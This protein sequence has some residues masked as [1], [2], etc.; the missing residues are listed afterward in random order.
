MD[1]IFEHLRLSFCFV[2]RCSNDP[3]V[4]YCPP[5]ADGSLP[6]M[7]QGDPWASL[8]GSSHSRPKRAS[9]RHCAR[10]VGSRPVIFRLQSPSSTKRRALD[11]SPPSSSRLRGKKRIINCT[12]AVTARVFVWDGTPPSSSFLSTV[13]AA[14]YPPTNDDFYGCMVG[15]A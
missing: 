12:V 14:Y 1:S 4:Q 7:C 8:L 9:T 5:C 10:R 11:G 6:C 15:N 3:I 13:W 2:N